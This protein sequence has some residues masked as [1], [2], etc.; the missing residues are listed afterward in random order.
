MLFKAWNL[1]FFV[2]D[3]N[4]NNEYTKISIF[5]F[6]NITGYPHV[7]WEKDLIIII[8]KYKL[9]LFFSFFFFKLI[10]TNT[11]NII[12]VTVIIILIKYFPFTWIN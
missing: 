10:Q 7:M 2:C 1:K 8:A 9:I 12:V 4:G 6:F 11:N 3:F 5:I